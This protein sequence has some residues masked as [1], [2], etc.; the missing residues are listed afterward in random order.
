MMLVLAGFVNAEAASGDVYTLG[1]V[2]QF[3]AARLQ[4]I[5]RPILQLLEKRT[6]YRFKLRVSHTIT[7]FERE[8]IQGTFDFAY[9]NPYQ[10]IIA[11]Q[12]KGYLP[13]VRDY[14]RQLC[15]VLV[16]RNDSAIDSPRDL[17]GRPVAYPSPNALGASLQM[18]QELYD[19]FG[20]TTGPRYVR[21]HDQVYQ[22]VLLGEADAGGGIRETLQE[23][24]PMYRN[25]L[26]VIYSTAK[27]P[28]HP[29]AASPRVPRKV[30][31]EVRGILL[32]M[33][34]TEQGKSLLAKIP[35]RRI[36][37]ANLKDYESIKLKDL[38]RFA[39]VRQ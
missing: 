16:V 2:P 37:S 26:R 13:L 34:K 11:N 14:G 10:L 4:R 36:G 38:D 19:L 12:A 30:R 33:G 27:I 5:W 3:D 7:E 9:M 21:T 25:A 1:V 20:V 17:Q 39:V 28:P 23:Q 31:Q 29:L 15:G 35:V 22:S 8:L 18:R 6:G 32:G 24:K